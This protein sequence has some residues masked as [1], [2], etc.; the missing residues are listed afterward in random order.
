MA[1]DLH[2]KP[3]SPNSTG[4]LRLQFRNQ[5]LLVTAIF[6]VE[7]H[8]QQKNGGIKHRVA[9]PSANAVAPSFQNVKRKQPKMA[10]YV[11]DKK[12]HLAIEDEREAG[13]RNPDGGQEPVA[14]DE[15]MEER[16]G[17]NGQ[18]LKRLRKFEPEEG[19]EDEDGLAEE[20]EEGQAAAAE[21]GEE[22]AEEVEE[23]GEVE[24]VGPEEH[25]PGGARA[26]WETE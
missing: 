22:G 26:E 24:N 19:S 20:V 21:D 13:G 16:G 5:R 25:A 6:P 15:E 4:S 23:S 11:A 12:S 7:L 18:D 1:I 10:E 17:E 9:G 2:N 8:K 3:I 14:V